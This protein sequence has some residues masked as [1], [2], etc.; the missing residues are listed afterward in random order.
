MNHPNLSD[1]IN[2]N[3]LRLELN[4]GLDLQALPIGTV[5][6]V[7]T[8]NTL[9]TLKKLD[10]KA[11][12]EIS[13]H[14]HFCPTPVKGW[15]AGSTWGGSMLKIGFIGNGMHM[16]FGV[17]GHRVLTTSPVREVRIKG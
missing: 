1:D 10:D 14:H 9:Y 15:V 7:Q 17:P 13:G 11:A 4:G 3:L 16:E 8:K 2:A 12:Y 6:E 5:I